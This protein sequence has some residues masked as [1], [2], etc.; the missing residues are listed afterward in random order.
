MT[1]DI[2]IHINSTSDKFCTL[3]NQMLLANFFREIVY[4]S[5]NRLKVPKV[6]LTAN[7]KKTLNLIRY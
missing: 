4:R 7:E 1:K 2:T 5:E 6:A 3:P